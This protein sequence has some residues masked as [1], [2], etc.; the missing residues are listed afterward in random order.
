MGKNKV[1]AAK[2]IFILIGAEKAGST[3]LS[4]VIRQHPE[5]RDP[6]KKGFNYFLSEEC[7]GLCCK[8]LFD[9]FSES[10]EKAFDA[11][12]SGEY[13]SFPEYPDFVDNIDTDLFVPRFIYAVRDPIERI[14]S[15]Y[16]MFYPKGR[17]TSPLS[18]GVDVRAIIRSNY[19]IQSKR[20][21]ERFGKD[22]IL[23]LN[24]D[25]WIANH[26]VATEKIARFMDIRASSFGEIENTKSGKYWDAE[27]YCRTQLPAIFRWG[28]ARL[29]VRAK[30]LIGQIIVERLPRQR[31]ERMREKAEKLTSM[32]DHQKQYVSLL[33]APDIEKFCSEFGVDSSTW[34]TY[35]KAVDEAKERRPGGIVSYQYS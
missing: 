18:H 32:T 27:M 23:I 2:E 24:F 4:Q 8:G 22:S 1:A 5:V 16:R 3:S 21:L 13:A 35:R 10:D 28:Y 9:Q 29:P 6:G 30:R 31:F 26:A 17:Y 14:Q 19:W 20:I 7:R 33:L 15:E 34:K 25:E 12:G 11:C